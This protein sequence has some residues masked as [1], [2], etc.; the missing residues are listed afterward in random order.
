MHAVALVASEQ[1]LHELEVDL[2]ERGYRHAAIREP[3]PPFNG[4]LVAIGVQPA[5]NDSQRM[6]D[7]RALMRKFKTYKGT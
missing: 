7:I 3:D 2:Q 1:Q 4:D 6:Q 5:Y